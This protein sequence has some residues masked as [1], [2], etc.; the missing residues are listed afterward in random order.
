MRAWLEGA[1]DLDEL[2]LFGR[3]ASP[4]LKAGSARV[5]S[6]ANKRLAADNLLR[7]QWP[8]RGYGL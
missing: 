4:G 7:R 8:R 6:F 1:D 2:V 5:F 3:A